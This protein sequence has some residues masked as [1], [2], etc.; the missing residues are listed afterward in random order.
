MSPL[1]QAASEGHYDCLKVLLD[2]NA[3]P[4]V[5]D[6]R[7]QLPIDLAKIWGHKKCAK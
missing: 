6:Y 1:H 2:N 4:F 5:L 7:G 3:D